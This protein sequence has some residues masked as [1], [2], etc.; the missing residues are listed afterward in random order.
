MHSQSV[1]LGALAA[2]LLLPFTNISSEPAA[3]GGKDPMATV[4]AQQTG[5]IIVAHGGD[6]LWNSYVH[7]MS[8]QVSSG[9]PVAV[10]F[11]MGP[12]AASTR[13]QDAVAK[14]ESAG[15]AR[16]VV[17]PL[18]VSSYSGHYDQVRY[19]AGEEV[20]LDEDMHHHLHMSGIT[21]P[22]TKLPLLV[23]SALDSAPHVARIVMERALLLARN[24]AQQALMIVGHGPNDDDD[25]AAW[26]RN[27]RLIADAV[28]AHA[29]FKDVRAEVVRD[30]A[31]P[32]VRAEAVKRVRE[33][34]ELQH[35]A[36]GQ[37][38]VVV[39]LLISSGAISRDKL[40]ADL[41]GLRMVYRG[42]PLLP[43][44]EVARWVESQVRKATAG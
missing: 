42:A 33:L 20:T 12:E 30:D 25:H 41:A 44:A 32:A 4:G 34:I 7:Q 38:V 9:G 40:P 2:V 11:L 5:T 14:L 3:A 1:S 35:L 31:P 16:I 22:T 37:D 10:S 21:R 8:K 26:M 19:L 18:L 15:V 39:P 24:P 13:F 23:T 28:R 36:T 43:H 17:V 29:G 6:S 27:L